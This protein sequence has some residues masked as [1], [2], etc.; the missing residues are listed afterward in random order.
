[1]NPDPQATATAGAK[2]SLRAQI[3]HFLYDAR[4]VFGAYLT[5]RLLIFAVILLSR[6]I[7][8]PSHSWH[9]GGLLSVLGQWDADLW[10]IEVA[11]NGYTFST[12][13]P[14]SVPFFPMFPILMKLVSF[15]FHDMRIAGFIVAHSCLLAAGLFLHALVRAEYND[16]RVSRVAVTFLMFNPAAFFFSHAYSESTFLMFAIASFFF[17]VK[18]RWLPA[19]LFA[20][21]LSAT[22]NVGVLISLSLFVEYLRQHRHLPFFGLFRPRVLYLGLAPLGLFGYLLFSYFKFGDPLAFLHASVIWDRKFVSPLVTWATLERY[23]PF[24]KAWFLTS[25]GAAMLLWVLGVYFR[26][27]ASYLLFAGLL[28]VMYWCANAMEAWPRYLSV[29]FPLY[30]V[31]G[32]LV[33]RIRWSYEPIL[34]GSITA[35][36]VATVLSAAGFWI[37]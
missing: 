6:M 37:T 5:S 11:R 12:H 18:G 28:T 17:A 19:C 33:S 29:E 20:M 22:R 14:S 10:Y 8:P 30:I 3:A 36:T 34:A 35:L 23:T 21:C 15:V 27:R 16:P 26:I 25:M 4:W 2:P 7:M 32:V 1:M 24:L 13:R 9:P 31:L